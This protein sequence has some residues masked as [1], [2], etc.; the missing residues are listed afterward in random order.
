M[1]MPIDLRILVLA[2]GLAAGGYMFSMLLWSY[3]Y[4]HSRAWPPKQATAAIKVRVWFMTITIFAAAFVL[5][6]LDWNRFEWSST[7][8]WSIGL[9]LI[10]IGNLV[11]WRGVLKIGMAATSGEASGLVTSG[12]YRWS[13]NPQYVADMAILIGWGVLSASFWA[14]PVLVI[15]LAVLAIAPLAEEPWLQEVYGV[16]Y[17]TYK[18]TVRRFI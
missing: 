6:L 13:R 3:V 14:L 2:T 11:V 16:K 5:G 4:P 17:S 10:L 15:G 12:L 1:T 9:P 8:R 7:V 18:Q